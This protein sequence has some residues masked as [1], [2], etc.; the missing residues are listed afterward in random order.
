MTRLKLYIITCTPLARGGVGN[1]ILYKFKD[2][3]L[4]FTNETDMLAEVIKLKKDNCVEN[5][6][7]HVCTYTLQD[8]EEYKI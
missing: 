6:K 7:V 1:P 8:C 5:I 4:E 2:E 3:T